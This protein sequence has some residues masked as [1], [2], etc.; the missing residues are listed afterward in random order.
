MMEN[1]LELY[2]RPKQDGMVGA[3]SLRSSSEVRITGS[4]TKH[5]AFFS[6]F[7]FFFYKEN[8]RMK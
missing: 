3:S 1:L 5:K 2:T 7:F 4:A 8:S 6:F